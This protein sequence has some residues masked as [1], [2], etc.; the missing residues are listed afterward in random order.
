MA[1]QSDVETALVALVSAALYPN[2]T[3]ADSVPGPVCSG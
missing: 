3:S 2:G 1:D